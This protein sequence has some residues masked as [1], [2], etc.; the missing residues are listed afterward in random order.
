MCWLH[1]GSTAGHSWAQQPS[2][3][4]LCKKVFTS[5]QKV[6]N[7]QRTVGREKREKEQCKHQGHWR[8]RRQCSRLQSRDSSAACG[9]TMLEQEK[10]VGREQ[11]R[12]TFVFVSIFLIIFFLIVYKLNWMSEVGSVLPM[13]VTNKQSSS[14]FWPIRFCI[15]L[16]EGSEW[17][18]C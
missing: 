1:S 13:M 7:W 6:L 5:V 9:E 16:R 11:Q 17:R 3:W 4:H 8:R 12:R 14:L 15:L 10:R 2:Q 18:V